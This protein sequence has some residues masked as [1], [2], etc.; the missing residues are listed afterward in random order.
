MTRKKKLAWPKLSLEVGAY[1]IEN[2]KKAMMKNDIF[3]LYH[4][5]E[6]PYY[7]HD[8]E[9]TIKSFIHQHDII[10]KYILDT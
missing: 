9:G 7:R 10:L 8:R 1:K 3:T 6:L 4:M 2:I 5:G